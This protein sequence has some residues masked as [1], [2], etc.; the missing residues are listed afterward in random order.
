[1]SRINILRPRVYKN[2]F[3]LL[4]NKVIRSKESLVDHAS[5]INL[6]H[7]T[8]ITSRLAS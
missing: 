4:Q 1:M 2:T 7:R 5:S 8:A 3:V 6:Q